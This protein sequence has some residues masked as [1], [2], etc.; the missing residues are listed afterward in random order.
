MLVDLVS[1]ENHFLAHKWPYSC[2]NLT[3]WSEGAL[4]GLFYFLFPGVSFKGHSSVHEL[5]TSQGPYLLI[6]SCQGLAF[7]T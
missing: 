4:W 3:Q 7:S 6:L 1:S 2:Y 5:I